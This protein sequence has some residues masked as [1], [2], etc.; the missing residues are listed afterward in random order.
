MYAATGDK[1]YIA[2]LDEEVN[3]KKMFWSRGSGWV[4]GVL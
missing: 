4:M 3:G 1:K 2:H